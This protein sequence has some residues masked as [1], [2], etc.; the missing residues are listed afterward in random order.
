MEIAITESSKVD[1]IYGETECVDDIDH[2]PRVE[3][4]YDCMRDEVYAL[5]I[6]E[7]EV[8]DMTITDSHISYEEPDIAE[9]TR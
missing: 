6:E 1:D 8:V 3:G 7:D 4:Y 2:K 5:T 9:L